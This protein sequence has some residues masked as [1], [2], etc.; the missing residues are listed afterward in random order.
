MCVLIISISKMFIM[1]D[2]KVQ[3]EMA[4]WSSN[5]PVAGFQVRTI[6]KQSDL[7]GFLFFFFLVTAIN[8]DICLGASPISDKII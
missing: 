1:Q 6:S 3:G 7:H 4:C 5:S 8:P 2:C